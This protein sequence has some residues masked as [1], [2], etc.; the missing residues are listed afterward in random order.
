VTHT[1]HWP[2]CPR[3][4]APRLWGCKKHWFELPQ[5]LRDRIWATYVPGQEVSKTPS[6]DYIAAA[7]DV[8]AWIA[9]NERQPRLL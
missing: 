3:I 1:C 5:H 9:G 8:Q 7:Q 4:V 6:R 2:G